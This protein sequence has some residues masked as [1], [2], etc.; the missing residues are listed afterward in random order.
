M[1]E[2]TETLKEKTEKKVLKKT[3]DKY[4]NFERKTF[5]IDSKV[6][7]L[8]NVE[9]MDKGTLGL[10]KGNQFD[11]AVYIVEILTGPRHGETFRIRAHDLKLV[12]VPKAE[13]KEKE[14]GELS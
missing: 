5:D 14:G 2:K 11:G 9:T 4:A 7:L 3:I 1:T 10:V 6:E 8:A 13:L 12:P